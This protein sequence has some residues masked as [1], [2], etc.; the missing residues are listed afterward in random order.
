MCGISGFLSSR[1]IP[2]EPVVRMNDLIRHRGPDD[3]GFVLFQSPV[4]QPLVCG[5]ADTP[6]DGYAAAL[7]WSPERRIAECRET[8]VT[9][10]LGHRRLAIVDL[11][12]GG[13][14]PMCTPDRRYWIVYNGEIYNHI[15]LRAELEALGYRFQSHSDTEVVLAAYAAWGPECL[16]RFNGMWAFALYDVAKQALFLARDRFG[17]KPLYYWVAPDG[18]FC[19]ASEIKQFTAFPGWSASLNPDAA[20]DYLVW[21][22]I[23]HTHQTLFSR[24]HQLRP[25]HFMYLDISR[26]VADTQ[27]R[28][29]STQ[30]YELQAA[31]FDGTFADAA[32]MFRER[33]TDAVRL[34]LR[35]DVPVGSCLSGGLDSSSIV[36]VVNRLLREQDA[37]QLQMSFSACAED[38]RVDESAWIDEV[39]RAT[40]VQAHYVCPAIDKLFHELPLITWHQDEPFSSTSIYAQW[41]VFRL[42]ARNNVKVMLDG[43]GADE[44]L[45]GYHMYFGPRFA[46]L[47]RAGRLLHLWQEIQLTKRAHG[48]SELRAMMYM[49]NVLLPEVIK[50]PL[51]AFAGRAYSKPSWL[52]IDALGVIPSDPLT[53]PGIDMDSIHNMSRAQLTATNLQMLLHWEDRDSMA[54]SVESRVPFLDYRLVEFVLGLPDEFKLSGGVTKRVQRTGMSGILP[55]RIRD[56]VDKIGF[57]TPEEVWLRQRVPNL[58]R[59]RMRRAVQAADGLFSPACFDMLEDII[60]GKKPFSHMPWRVINFGEWIN[61]FSVSIK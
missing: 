22:L 9:L 43:Q 28:V 42:A 33:F 49:A 46:A 2:A 4:S 53:R 5:G 60:D 8:P 6:R 12:P 35:A 52:N 21:G 14:Q 30:W 36:C 20:Y 56:R 40:G 18:S 11:S 51:R 32:Q 58:F 55:P 27:G 31:R 47:L 59:T 50:Q 15:E 54:H 7:A 1:A 44:Q 17:I 61:T 48:Y 41:N 39:V 3:E 13:H 23:D 16:R 10:A 45:A 25:G 37:T 29:D 19:F 34:H 26:I 57:A 24:V 38:K